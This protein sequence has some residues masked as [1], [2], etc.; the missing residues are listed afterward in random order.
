M[1]DNETFKPMTEI[2]RNFT[3]IGW[4]DEQGIRH[5]F[6]AWVAEQERWAALTPEEKEVER[7]AEAA[8]WKA[9]QEADELREQTIEVKIGAVL[10]YE[11]FEWYRNRLI[12]KYC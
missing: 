6:P 7:K 5:L 3:P 12:G 2:L 4:D 9:E 10:S 1:T 8:K 11:D